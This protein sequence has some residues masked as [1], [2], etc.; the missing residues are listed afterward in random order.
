M[1]TIIDISSVLISTPRLTLRPFRPEDLEDFFAYASVPGVGEMAGWPHHETIQDTESILNTFISEKSVLAICIDGRA[2]GSLGLH[3][4]WAN[5]TAEYSHLII[6]EIG[7]V[8]SKEHWGQGIMPEAVGAVVEYGFNALGIEAFTCS[9]SP[10]NKRS[11]RVIEKSGF[12]FVRQSKHFSQQ[13]QTSRDTKQYILLRSENP[14]NLLARY[15]SA[16]DEELRLEGNHGQVEFLTTMRYIERYLAPGAQVLE[17]GAGTGRYSRAIADLGYSVQAVEL[18]QSNINS[19]KEKI[20]DGQDIALSQAN[21]IDLGIFSDN[22]FDITLLLGPLYHLFTEE[23]KHK[24]LS[25]AL[26][27]TKQG[28]IVFAAYCISDASIVLSG[29]Q[30]KAFDIAEYIARG[31]IDP[32]SFNTVSLPHEDAFE[33]IRKEG[34]DRL[35]S[36]YRVQRLH[37][38]A[39]DLFANYMRDAIDA[40]GEDEFALYMS[41]HFSA[42]ERQDMVGITH[43]SL[44][45]FKKE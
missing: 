10:D 22:S 25:E 30:R 41:Y 24:A 31:K 40:M 42:C 36:K 34:I 13:L 12:S 33:L 18:F 29:F 26:R 44:D 17:I 11:Q 3:S 15:Y 5:E 21:A 16:S 1:D 23:D 28:G 6:K 20:K 38:I 45:V 9:H 39:T 2:V 19:F 27:V 32:L 8:L 7:Y 37:Y 4:S 35:M 14:V 43:H